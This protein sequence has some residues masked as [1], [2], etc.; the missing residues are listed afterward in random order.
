MLFM[1]AQI[2]LSQWPQSMYRWV[3]DTRLKLSRK[4]FVHVVEYKN[5]RAVP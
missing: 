4:Q 5:A 2:S 1:R 3:K